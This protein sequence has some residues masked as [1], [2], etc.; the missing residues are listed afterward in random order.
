MLPR[1]RLPGICG[2]THQISPGHDSTIEVACASLRSSAF[3]LFFV[4]RNTLR[5]AQWPADACGT[6][7][8]PV[9]PERVFSRGL[10]ADGEAQS[11]PPAA[12]AVRCSAVHRSASA[13][14]RAHEV[15]SDASKRR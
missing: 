7:P 5:G 3:G 10:A 11:R 13:S 4:S 12:R 6:V 8:G 1:S 2:I 14:S 15:P 9:A